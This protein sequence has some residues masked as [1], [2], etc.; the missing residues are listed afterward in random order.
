MGSFKIDLLEDGK[1]Y[2]SNSM[3]F[4][5]H[6]LLHLFF[7]HRCV[8]FCVYENL[9]WFGTWSNEKLGWLRFA[10]F[11]PS[12]AEAGFIGHI[13]SSS[14]GFFA[15]S[16]LRWGGGCG[17][18]LYVVFETIVGIILEFVYWK[19]MIYNICIYI[20]VYAVCTRCAWY[21][22]MYVW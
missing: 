5:D 22:I 11:G 21:I 14:T 16:K 18:E 10:A 13:G 3:H 12:Q 15:S 6:F 7:L 20:Y 17:Q 4:E 2:S 19:C 8:F 9:T 1:T